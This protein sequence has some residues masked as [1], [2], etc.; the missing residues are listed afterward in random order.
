MISE[1][2]TADYFY[3]TLIC[4]NFFYF[5]FRK[6][7]SQLREIRKKKLSFKV[8]DFLF[9]T[10]ENKSLLIHILL[11]K[12]YETFVNIPFYFLLSINQYWIYLYLDRY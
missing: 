4:N 3:E 6:S 2:R 10:E 12:K 9:I 8:V 7:K 5:L 11:L 1:I